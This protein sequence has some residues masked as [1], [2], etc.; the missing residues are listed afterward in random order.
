MTDEARHMAVATATVVAYLEEMLD[1]CIDSSHGDG[2]GE[3]RE[4]TLTAMA[5]D[6]LKTDAGISLL[7]TVTDA[8]DRGVK[9]HVTKPVQ[10]R[11]IANLRKMREATEITPGQLDLPFDLD[12]VH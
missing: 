12:A 5:M 7:G 10:T 11:A 9:M 8:L 2:A 3:K 1:D 4:E 6:L